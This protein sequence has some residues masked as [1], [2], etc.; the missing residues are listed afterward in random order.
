MLVFTLTASAALAQESR[1]AATPTPSEATKAGPAQDSRYAPLAN[2][3]KVTLE[4]VFPNLALVRPIQMLQAPGETGGTV[5]I[6]EQPG[7]VLIADLT[8]DSATETAVALDIRERVN[9]SGNEEGL[10]SLAFHPNFPQRR[11]VFVYYTAA[12]P[13]RSI[14]SRFA[15]GADGRTID[16]AS[17]EILLTQAQ[18]YSNHNGGTCLFGPDGYMYLSLGDGGAADDPHGN[19]QNPKTFLSK[20]LRIDVNLKSEGKAYAIPKDNPFVS[21]ANVLPEIWATGTRNIWRMQFDRKTGDL[22]AGDVGQNRYEEID[23]VKKGC[24][25]GWNVREGF[26]AF[27]RAK[28]SDGDAVVFTEPVIEHPRREGVSITGGFVCRDPRLPALEGVY[29]YADFGYGSIWGAKLVGEKCTKPE[30]LLKHPTT[31][32][33]SF[34]EM[35]DASLF[36]LAFDGG[37]ERRNPGSIWKIQVQ[38]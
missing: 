4:R 29:L 38:P 22:W 18:P 27:G 7:R 16:P 25:F 33:T 12:D 10:L 15:V 2:I 5:F 14:L 9:D 20:V 36:V 23:I 3:P 8:Q 17:E 28:P 6:V 31:L 13:R 35:N 19:G 21:D 32:F 24:N 37:Q 1:P 26:H 30:L 11:E 34:A